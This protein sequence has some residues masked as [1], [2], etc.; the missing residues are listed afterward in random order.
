MAGIS[1]SQ[2]SRL[3]QEIDERVR[4]FLERPIE[5]DWPCLWID[6]TYV[7]VRRGWTHRFGGGDRRRRR[8]APILVLRAHAE[9]ISA[10]APG[11][12][13]IEPSLADRSGRQSV[14]MTVGTIRGWGKRRVKWPISK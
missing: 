12:S 5:G 9:C 3:C 11:G 2:V 4:T 7:K 13:A 14:S 1:K 8:R 10:A 6:A